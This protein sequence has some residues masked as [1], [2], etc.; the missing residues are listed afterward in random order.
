M[1][2]RGDATPEKGRMRE[3]A[4]PTPQRRPPPCCTAVLPALQFFTD[5]FGL[6]LYMEPNFED[7]SC[8]MMFGQHPPALEADK[9]YNQPCFTS[10]VGGAVGTTSLG[11]CHC[12]G[13]ACCCCC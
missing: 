12:V 13:L 10:Q 3:R 2:E 4:N 5:T 11:G 8:E 6:P 1:R 9:L 7:L